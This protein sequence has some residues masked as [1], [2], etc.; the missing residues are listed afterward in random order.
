[1][2]P[3]GDAHRS[4][5]SSSA[6]R[7]SRCART[8]PATQRSIEPIDQVADRSASRRADD[9]RGATLFDYLARARDRASSSSERDEVDAH[10]AKLV[11]QIQRSYEDVGEARRKRDGPASAGE[12]TPTLRRRSEL[13]ATP[14]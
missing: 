11:E 5:W 3:A 9:D 1:M 2:F 6:T 13:R 10:A 7:S 12:W 8:I 14:R 4:G